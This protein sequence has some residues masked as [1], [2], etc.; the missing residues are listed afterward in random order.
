MR[1]VGIIAEYNPLHNGHIYHMEQAKALSGADACVVVMSGN[2]VQRGE[3]ACTDKFTRTDWAL[4]AGADAVFELP[5]IFALSS[6]ERFAI[7]GVRTL[8]GMGVITDLAFG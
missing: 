1:V 3:P 8:A 5:S 2:F 4:K 6:A 7:G